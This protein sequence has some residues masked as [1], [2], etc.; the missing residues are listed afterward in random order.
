MPSLP[1]ARLALAAGLYLL[2]SATVA[3]VPPILISAARTEQPGLDIPAARTVIDE[4]EIAASGAR[5]IDELL[6]RVSSLHVADGI[7]DGG[8]SR[9]DMRGFG[10]AATSNVAV[11]V[12]GRKINPASDAATLYLNSIDIDSIAQIEIIEGSAGTLYG[13]QAVGG[14]INIVTR[15]PQRRSR[16]L[17]IGAGSYNGRA[18]SA[19]L[20]ETLAGAGGLRVQLERR[21]SD[22]YRDQNASRVSRFDTRVELAHDNGRSHIDVQVLDDDVQTPG[23][24]LAAEL[25]ADRR[26]AAFTGD[27]LDTESTV[28][29]FGTQRGLGGDWQFEGEVAVRDDRREFVQSFRGFPGSLS[30]QDRDSIEITPR[31]VGRAAGSVV[32]LGMDW[33]S[34]DYLLVTAFGTQGNDQAI[35]AWYAQLTHP[36]SPTLSVT[37]GVRHARVDNAIDNNGTPVDLDDDITVGSLGLVYR[38][39]PDWRLF[40]RADQNYRFAK[41]DEHTN[42]PFGQPVGLANQR[43]VSYESGASYRRNGWRVALSAYQLRLDDEISFDATTF[44]NVNL[45]RSRRNGATLSVDANLTAELSGGV[46]YTWT[47]AEITSGNHAGSRVPLVPEH[48]ATAFLAYRP[49]LDWQAR[50]D[51]EHVDRQFLGS[52]FANLSAPLDAYTVV[53]LVAHRD[54]GDWRLSAKL[55]NLFNERYSETGA[56][57]FAGD[58]FIPAPERNA[59]ICVTYRTGD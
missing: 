39:T 35:Q 15:R 25:A 27:Y 7:G 24:L 33:L 55:N 29:R 34:T 9:I 28:L 56:R 11:L 12:N 52:D 53:N 14:L 20:S 49:S 22:N 8:G 59:W 30:T 43:G 51:V 44:T 42:V 47:D 6:R 58:G 23:A 48:R 3:G 45:P 13:N 26:Q 57:S 16:T 10:A 17:R 54:I 2:S 4:R 38:P 32:T 1:I 36:L 41:V 37:A 31:L 46:G 21:D 19:T 50:V 5:D 40:A 18:A